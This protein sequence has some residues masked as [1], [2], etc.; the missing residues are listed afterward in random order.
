MD[1]FVCLCGFSAHFT[2]TLAGLFVVSVARI[3]G[4]MVDWGIILYPI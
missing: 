4:I 1:M 3:A 2:A